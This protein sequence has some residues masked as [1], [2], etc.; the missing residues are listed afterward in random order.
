MSTDLYVAASSQIAMNKRMEAIANNIANMN[1]AGYRAAGVKFQAAMSHVGDEQVAYASPGT[2]Y[3]LRE[4]GPVSYTGNSLDVAIDGDGWLA[5]KSPQGTIYTRDG[6]MHM[7]DRGELQ[8][9]N[10]YSVLD[11]GGSPITLDPAGGPVMIGE[12]GGISQ[13]GTQVGAVG[14]F[15]IA[16]DAHLTRFDNSAVIPDKPA[17]AV[18]D[19]TTNSVR[20][21]Y[22][23]GSNVNPILEMTRLIEVSRAFDQAA[24]AIDDSDNLSQEAIRTLSPAG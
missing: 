19:V 7:T 1:T 22:V 15:L 13:G 3:I 24:T 9:V 10:G 17:K 14:L 18:E 12:S 4:S 16:A 5:L 11:P 8:S 20:Q 6:R 23:E 21:G 2:V